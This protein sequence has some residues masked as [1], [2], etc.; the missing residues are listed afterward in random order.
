MRTPLLILLILFA[1]ASNGSSQII[2]H[3]GGVIGV[4]NSTWEWKVGGTRLD[5]I[6]SRL[7]ANVGVFVE[8][9]EVPTFSLL[10]EVRFV[11]KGVKDRI[12]I[13]SQQFPEGT[14]E[15]MKGNI[16][17]DYLSFGLFPKVRLETGI[18]EIY[19]MAG[20]RV[21]MASSNK[22][23]VEGPVANRAN[24]EQFYN[25]VLDKFRKTELGGLVGLGA[26]FGGLI[27]I[28][29]G[30]EFRYSPS[31]QESFSEPF[32]TIRSTSFEFIV[33]LSM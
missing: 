15:F 30:L 16:R 23:H 2:R 29:L 8:W 31:F 4:T 5:Q 7:G 3:Y 1:C 24:V 20:I 14:G 21:D 32:S 10:S 9:L 12:P 26:R 28:P 33:T 22:L 18:V 25:S 11:Q 27:P 19:A 6:E 17:T 13:T